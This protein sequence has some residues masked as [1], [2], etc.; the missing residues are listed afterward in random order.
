MSIAI[1]RISISHDEKEYPKDEKVVEA[2]AQGQEFQLFAE[3]MF[4]I[5]KGSLMSWMTGQV[6]RSGDI[7]YI[8]VAIKDESKGSCFRVFDDTVYNLKKAI[9]FS[10]CICDDDYFT[11]KG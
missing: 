4:R 8:S 3:G 7:L 5:N 1:K 11:L 6:V 10:Y 2:I 9:G